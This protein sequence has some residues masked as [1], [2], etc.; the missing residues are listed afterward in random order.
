MYAARGRFVE[1][2][3]DHRRAG[4]VILFVRE[5]TEDEYNEYEKYWRNEDD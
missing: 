3:E 4:S 1:I 5:L 2:A